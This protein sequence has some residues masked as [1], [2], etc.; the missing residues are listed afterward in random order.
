MERSGS[1]DRV[2][3]AS[4]LRLCS[5]RERDG[6]REWS[7]THSLVGGWCALQ[8]VDKDE[9][10]RSAWVCGGVIGCVEKPGLAQQR[11][12]FFDF[13]EKC[14]D[15]GSAPAA[16]HVRSS[17]RKNERQRQQILDVGIPTRIT[18][19]RTSM[20]LYVFV[21]FFSSPMLL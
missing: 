11:A 6:R 12:A 13:L 20:Y 5:S 1:P 21:Y 3:L 14:S 18:P 19:F 9:T 15:C 4:S 7:L 17:T 2:C 16:G 8:P 10:A